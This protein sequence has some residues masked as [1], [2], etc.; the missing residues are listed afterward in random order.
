M[1]R[2]GR[3][4]VIPDIMQMRVRAPASAVALP[5]PYSLAYDST[6]GADC[7]DDASIVGLNAAAFTCD[8]YWRASSSWGGYS[9]RAIISQVAGASDGWSIVAYYNG[10]S[11]D[12]LM[13]TFAL[14]RPGALGRAGFDFTGLAL[15]AWL[16]VRMRYDGFHLYGSINAG[17]ETTWTNVWGNE[18]SAGHL[19]IGQ[20]G[21]GTML[22]FLGDTCYCHI[23]NVDKGAL[24]SVPTS[25]L[26]VDANT[27]GRWTHS[28]GAGTTLGDDSGAGND[29]AIT[30][31]AWGTDVPAGWTL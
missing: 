15:N 30:G 26:A 6:G 16:Y 31:A 5:T 18:T 13:V 27:V 25:P 22:S 20:D 10:V 29:G 1:I 28:E 7:G 21:G 12:S 14:G 19:L 2:A 24:A 11:G 9:R 4:M 3:H 17:V 8:M 23:W